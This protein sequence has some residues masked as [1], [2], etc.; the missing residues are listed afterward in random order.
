MT[1]T[2]APEPEDFIAPDPAELALMQAL[3]AGATDKGLDGVLVDAPE[4]VEQP[5]PGDDGA[6]PEDD[7][8]HAMAAFATLA[9]TVGPPTWAQ[10]YALAKSFIAKWAKG[11][12][13]ENVNDFTQWYYGDNTSA[14]FCFIF[15]SYVLA[16]AAKTQAA[17]LALIGGKKAY[18]PYIRNVSGEHSGHSGVKVGAIAAVNSF[19][20]IGF[21]VRVGSTTFDLLSGN[22]TNGSSDDA[23]TVKTYSLSSISGYVNLRY[24]APAPA[25]PNAYPGTVYRYAKGKTLMAGSH[26]KWIQTRLGAHGHKVATDS[27]YGPKTA[28]A[29]MAFQRGAKLTADG[30]VGPKTWAALAK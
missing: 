5:E 19:N 30:Q 29:V 18:V 12:V 16:H 27:A 3:P 8:P 4:D 17:G 1:D 15:I 20:H 22:S 21:V 13:R 28:A 2:T 26:V 14:A 25:N 24:A 23:V 6:E 7:A 11:R 9:A 10:V